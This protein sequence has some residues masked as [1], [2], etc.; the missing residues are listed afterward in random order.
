MTADTT[1]GDRQLMLDIYG[2]RAARDEGIALVAAN[3][4]EWW[5]STVDTAIAH[6][7]RQGGE[8][9]SDDIRLLGVDEPHHHNAWGARFSAAAKR[10]VIVRVGYRQSSRVAGHA[11]VIAVWRGSGA[12]P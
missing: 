10:G 4:D 2:A 1:T 11:R 12:S 7:A 5:R 8:F 9:T 6:L 3:S